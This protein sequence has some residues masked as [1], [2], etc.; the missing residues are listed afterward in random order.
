[1]PLLPPLQNGDDIHKC[2]LDALRP[3]VGTK[4]LY[5]E[6]SRPEGLGRMQMQQIQPQPALQSSVPHSVGSG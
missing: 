4:C 3:A 5:Q 2:A 1:M 6:P